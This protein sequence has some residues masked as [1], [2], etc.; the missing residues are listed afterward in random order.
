[1]SK[2]EKSL[3]R[4]FGSCGKVAGLSAIIAAALLVFGRMEE[5]ASGPFR[6]RPASRAEVRAPVS[7]FLKAVDT[8]EGAHV[9]AGGAV[10]SLEIPDLA[11]RHPLTG[12]SLVIETQGGDGLR[13]RD[14]RGGRGN[15]RLPVDSGVL[16]PRAERFPKR[17]RGVG[18]GAGEWQRGARRPVS[19]RGP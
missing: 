15:A 1:M 4:A 8:D 13:F 6:L 17:N 3:C 10:G 11:S 12:P 7:G 19:E 5:K 2:Q 14:Q 9:S 16:L 18:R